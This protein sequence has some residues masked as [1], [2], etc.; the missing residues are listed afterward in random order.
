MK[1]ISNENAEYNGNGEDEFVEEIELMDFMDHL[2]RTSGE[3][4]FCWQR[5]NGSDKKYM[6]IFIIAQ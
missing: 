4:S 1:K 3:Y 2:F 6:E 5:N